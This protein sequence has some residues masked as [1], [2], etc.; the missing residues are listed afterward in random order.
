MQRTSISAEVK[1]DMAF[2]QRYYPALVE[3]ATS[4]H[5]LPRDV[6][7]TLAHDILLS[8]LRQNRKSLDM[9]AWLHGAITHAATR[10]K[11]TAR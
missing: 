3:V 11:D 10:I 8:S 2:Y 6:A 9:Q 1:Q 4:K 7:E 5:Q